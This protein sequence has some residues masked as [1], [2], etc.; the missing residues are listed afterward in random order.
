ME[1]TPGHE[2]E[3]IE[4][5]RRAMYS[6]SWNSEYDNQ[7]RHALEQEHSRV[8]EDW[9]RE[10]RAVPISEKVGVSPEAM[11]GVR[12]F[13]RVLFLLAGIFFIG[14]I[15][16]F[17]YNFTI[18]PSA[19]SPTV[20]K[21][22]IAV[23]GPT[24]ISGGEATQLQIIVT[25]KNSV[26]LELAQLV[27]TYPSG[28]RSPIDHQTD[29][30]SQRI[31]LGTI[32]PGGQ[33][34]GIV[35]AVFAGDSNSNVDVKVELEYRLSGS[36][37]IFVAQSEYSTVLSS[38]PISLSVDARQQTIS[39]QPIEVTL[40]V[41]SNSD[42]SIKDVLVSADYPFGFAFASANPAP[43]RPGVWEIGDLLPGQKRSIVLRGTLKGESG[44][45]RTFHFA[46]GTRIAKTD[47]TI[48]TSLASSAYKMTIS[49]SFLGLTIAVNDAAGGH[50]IVLSPGVPVKVSV[51]YQNNLQ[52]VINDAIIVARIS[53][54]QIDGAQVQT[55][56]GFYR[57]TDG[58]VLWDK[59]TTNGA[60]ASLAPG[61]TGAVSFSFVLPASADLSGIR[62][63]SLS[64]SVNAAGKRVSETGVPQSLQSSAT[65]KIA[66]ASD[67]QVTAVSLYNS[68][69]FKS[70]GPLPPKASVETTYAIAFTVT[71]TTNQVTGGKLTA[72]LPPFVR[73]T[74][75]YGPSSEK[76]T[77]NKSEGVFTWD[78]GAIAPGVGL[79]GSAPRQIVIGIGLTPSQSQVGQELPLAQD[80]TFT[81]ADAATGVAISRNV[82][83]TTTRTTTDAGFVP[84]NATVV[85]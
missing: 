21:V 62:A 64:L 26:P 76:V 79:N 70:T 41:A 4:R 72:R 51:Q 59:N 73:W 55:A 17:V 75:T 13:F 61:A 44:D 56:D 9:K 32:P 38:S 63:P 40:N 46:A 49:N 6:R 47:Q 1:D 58:T 39:G 31:S 16:F 84:T 78:V 52:T 69:P 18:S 22:D 77:F 34:P 67:L 57:S 20:S 3:K 81:G 12:S 42:A 27:V 10:P 14:A 15:G 8:G 30:S 28:T 23:L 19:V 11:R 2:Q 53:G 24:R 48:K 54:L 33:L 65:Q 7:P 82:D 25:N 83:D 60:L 45:E 37:A 5:L 71:N 50:D 35:T 68:N 85:R 36:S 29:L 43:V 66:L 74:G 80:I